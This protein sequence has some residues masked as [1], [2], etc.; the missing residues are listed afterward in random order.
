METVSHLRLPKYGFGTERLGYP[1]AAR[2]IQSAAS[3]S[4]KVG[5]GSLTP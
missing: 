4:L 2:H 1:P 5:G 3:A